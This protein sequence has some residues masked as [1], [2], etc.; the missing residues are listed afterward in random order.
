MNRFL[1]AYVRSSDPNAGLPYHIE[2]FKVSDDC[3]A[4][5]VTVPEKT[6]FFMFANAN[7][8]TPKEIVESFV[9]L[10]FGATLVTSSSLD[11]NYEE[12]GKRYWVG[13]VIS[14]N[15]I[16]VICNEHAKIII[17]FTSLVGNDEVIDL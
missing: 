15:G 1:I 4:N 8:K 14:K 2:S 7:V 9:T 13:K 11:L 17:P 3:T 16:Q 12:D 6:V 10:K 5:D